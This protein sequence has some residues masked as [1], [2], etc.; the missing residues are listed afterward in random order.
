[1]AAHTPGS[2]RNFVG[3]Q[4]SS[5]RRDD[6]A[7]VADA[8]R[9]RARRSPG[10]QPPRGGQPGGVRIARPERR[11]YSSRDASLVAPQG[12]PADLRGRGGRGHELHD[13]GSGA[14]VHPGRVRAVVGGCGRDRHGLLRGRREHDTG[15]RRDR[16][17]DRHAARGDARIP[18]RGDRRPRRGPAGTEL[19]GAA[20]LAR[21]GRPRVGLRLRR[22]RR[23]HQLD[24]RR[25]RP[26][27]RPGPVRGVVPAG[28]GDHPG[29]RPD[30][31]RSVRRLAAGLHALRPGRG[32]GLGGVD[33]PRPERTPRS[34]RAR[35]EGRAG[36]RPG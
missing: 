35:G 11:R 14:R 4:I 15:W 25:S 23:V 10:G 13:P 34:G 32:R 27:S 2:R 20:G 30:P 29:L 31:G 19:P 33:A 8:C 36:R 18:A 12:S 16:R 3:G 24:L 17:S 21:P 28:V 5:R 1:M 22:R 6:P 26:P 7:G 9:G